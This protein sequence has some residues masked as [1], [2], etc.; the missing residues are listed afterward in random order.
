MDGH[1]SESLCELK[2]DM[3][4]KMQKMFYEYNRMHEVV[5]QKKTEEDLEKRHMIDT[6]RNLNDQEQIRL[7]TIQCLESDLLK[8]QKTTHDYAEMIKSL[9]DKLAEKDKDTQFENKF[10]MIRIQADELGKKDMEIERLNKLIFNLK[11]RPT[12]SSKKVSDMQSQTNQTNQ[13]NQT[14]EVLGWSP[15]SSPSPPPNLEVIDLLLQKEPEPKPI[16]EEAEIMTVFTDGACS[17]NGKPNAKAGIGIY[18]G[19]DDPRNVSRRIAGTQTNNVAE[20]SAIIEVFNICTDNIEG[21]EEV[22][23]YSDSKVAIGWCTTTGDKYESH[24]WKKKN[25]D[26][27][28]IDLVKLGHS[29]CKKNT[30]VSLKH[31]KAHTGDKDIL[32]VGNDM[33][34]T[35]ATESLHLPDILVEETEEEAEEEEEEEEEAEIF[36]FRKKEYYTVK[37]DPGQVVYGVLEGDGKGQRLGVWTLTK[38]GNKKPIF[39]GIK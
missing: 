1:T 32:S 11:K 25:G 27:P 24:N 26:I 34:D 20:L 22:I 6:I 36:M 38:K 37:G 14:K 33:A 39:D 29:L 18:F 2:N 23:I 19:A 17:N 9:E 28:N 31:V 16:E 8:S 12:P 10:S 21:G 30:N 13:T 15:T 7:T 5:L 4:E 35:L 3:I